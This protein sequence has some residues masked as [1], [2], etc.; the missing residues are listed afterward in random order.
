MKRGEK[1]FTTIEV[2]VAL[3][4]VALITGGAAMST[5]QIIQGAERT[6]DHMIAIRHAQSVG[7]WLSNDAMIARNIDIGDNPETG[8]DEFI[9]VYWKNWENGDTHEI[10]YIWL[11]SSGGLKKLNRNHVTRNKDGVETDNR[12]AFVADNI[13]T[14]SLS[15]QDGGWRLNVEA[16]SGAKSETREY[17]I[18]KRIEF[19]E[20]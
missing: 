16:R 20:W 5:V 12:T 14:A 6:S 10:R 15:E 1:G 4:I 2:L 8:D 7:Y 3:A 11:D 19:E 17:E 13:Y 9:T 18:S